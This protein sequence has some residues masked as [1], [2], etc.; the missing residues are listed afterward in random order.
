MSD[1]NVGQVVNGNQ[2]VG[3]VIYNLGEQ[4]KRAAELSADEL[5][6]LCSAYARA[7]TARSTRNAVMASFVI[8]EAM[9]CMVA[10]HWIWVA[11]GGAATGTEMVYQK[12]SLTVVLFVPVVSMTFVIAGDWWREQREILSVLRRERAVLLAQA[13][14]RGRM[15][16]G[17]A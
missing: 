3:Q 11:T 4:A 9:L 7:I 14:V 16:Q 2:H 1:V 10:A 8:A 5:K 17:G 12:L 6:A 13:D 15:P